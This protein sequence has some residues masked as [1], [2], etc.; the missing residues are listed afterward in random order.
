MTQNS[1]TYSLI[2]FTPAHSTQAGQ[3]SEQ[4]PVTYPAL[5]RSGSDLQPA[6]LA[7]RNLSVVGGGAAEAAAQTSSAVSKT[8]GDP[9]ARHEC[10]R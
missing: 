8:G 6:T 1:A 4:W 2:G 3:Y 10:Q 5:S 9:D 7:D